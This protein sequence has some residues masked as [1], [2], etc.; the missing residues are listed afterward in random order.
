M[1]QIIEEYIYAGKIKKDRISKRENLI[2]MK[3]LDYIFIMSKI[4]ANNLIL[5]VL[6]I[7]I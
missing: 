3:R 7:F 5:I 2:I 6:K 1:P 4:K